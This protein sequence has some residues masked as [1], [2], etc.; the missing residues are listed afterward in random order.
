MQAMRGLRYAG[1]AVAVG[2]AVVGL[3]GCSTYLALNRALV[4][5]DDFILSEGVPYGPESRLVLDVYRPRSGASAAKTIVFFYGG[6]WRS[7]ERGYYR[8]IGEALTSRGFVVVIPDYR[9]YPEVRFPEFVEDGAQAL[10]WTTDHIAA[11]GGD[12][13]RVYLMG[14]SAGAHIA[15][16]LAL[17]RRFLEEAGV[18]PQV[19]RGL[20]GVAGPYA[21]DP[22]RYRSTRPVFAG[23]ADPAAIQP[24]SFVTGG[25]PPVLLLHGSLDQVVYPSNSH[26]LASTL[27]QYGGRAKVV[28]VPDLGHIGA[29]LAFAEPLRRSG[30]V[31]DQVA[32][33]VDRH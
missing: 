5:S 33:F 31:R 30:G 14:H 1:L 23:V 2:L 11:F 22:F 4:S 29:I 32:A 15:A 10:R 19:I 12:P 17:D 3:G 6:S 20:I 8:F 16:L 25:E 24:G 21:F 13:E 7:G 18:P 27:H 28:E 9:L 26:A